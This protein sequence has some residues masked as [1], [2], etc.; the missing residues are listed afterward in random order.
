MSCVSSTAPPTTAPYKAW[1]PRGSES[2]N[3]PGGR[4]RLGPARRTGQQC[5]SSHCPSGGRAQNGRPET[6]RLSP[7]TRE[8][9]GLRRCQ[10]TFPPHEQQDVTHRRKTDVT[11]RRRGL[12]MQH[13]GRRSCPDPCGY[14]GGGRKL[15]H[16]RKPGAPGLLGGLTR[17]RPPAPQSLLGTLAL[18]F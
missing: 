1:I 17:G 8:A 3:E 4:H 15:G 7:C 16:I 5:G 14:L 11:D 2:A 18:P 13:D 12:L 9:G 10:P 6:N